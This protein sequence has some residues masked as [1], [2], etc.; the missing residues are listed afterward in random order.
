MGFELT[1]GYVITHLVIESPGG[2]GGNTGLP[3]STHVSWTYPFHFRESP[4]PP[5][6]SG[7]AGSYPL[8][9]P[10]VSL[11][12]IILPNEQD[13]LTSLRRL[14]VLDTPKEERFDRITRLAARVLDFPFAA[15]TLIDSDRQWHKSTVGISLLQ[16]PRTQSFC[17]HAVAANHGYVVFDASTDARFR[18]NPIVVNAPQIRFYASEVI[19]SA[20]GFALGTLCI[21]DSQP[22][23]FSD[24]DR[25]I[26]RDL[27]A[28]VERE[29]NDAG[30]PKLHEEKRLIDAAVDS[31]NEGILIYET[32]GRDGHRV[33]YANPAFLRMTGYR[34]LEIVGRSPSFL[35][36]PLTDPKVVVE[37]NDSV[38][39]GRSFS[40][41]IV[42]YRKDGT[43][44]T[45]EW[46]V[47]P[48]RND[49][50]TVTHVI[51]VWR[52]ISERKQAE[53]V[54]VATNAQLAHA[55]Q[56]ADNASQ[57][58]SHFLASMSHELRTPLNGIMGMAELLGNSP[59]TNDQRDCVSTIRQSS[60]NLLTIISDVLDFSKIEFGKLE[61]DPQPFSPALL[62][63]DVISLLGGRAQKAGIELSSFV[64]PELPTSLVGD[65]NRLRQV[66]LNLVGNAIKFTDR[67]E[68]RLELLCGPTSQ[69]GKPCMAVSVC[70]TGIG[71][72]AERMGR[73]FQLFSQVDPSTTRV[74]GGT[75]LGLAIAQRLVQL[76][77]GEIAV[78]SDVGRGSAFSFAVALPP[79]EG[80]RA[81]SPNL[82]STRVALVDSNILA[83]RN[84][85]RQLG[86]WGAH[87]GEFSALGTTGTAWDAMMVAVRSRE[88]AVELIGTLRSLYAGPIIALTP[89]YAY[90]DSQALA[91]AGATATLSLPF[92]QAALAAA[93]GA[94]TGKPIASVFTPSPLAPK[95][96][97]LPALRVLVAEDNSTNRKVAL[98]M[99]AQLG[100]SAEV[101]SSGTEAVDLAGSRDYDVILMD[102]HMPDLDGLEAS[103]RIRQALATARR[104]PYIIAMTA[105]ALLGDREK[106]LSAGMDNYITKPV[107]L[108]L[109]R[110]ALAGSPIG[111]DR[112]A[113][114]ERT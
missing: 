73:L 81:T 69:G 85:A 101:A 102:V 110:A 27:A 79:A 67:G 64:D 10:T 49:H 96:A 61:F 66:L 53:R 80:A 28:L 42:N 83:R 31:I 50:G 22:R 4:P 9:R 11:A 95:E 30:D 36:G 75:G 17:A 2:Q 19:R 93:V 54:L 29:I 59:L 45:S 56:Q 24:S 41:E 15:V 77:G 65:A 112:V 78:Q 63:D 97:E 113:R 5:G 111:L 107:K 60:E 55:K 108:A 100:L 44:F 105:D 57:A 106:C 21:M 68:V 52:D 38:Q 23:S 13:R 71:I 1:P 89:A 46:T 6:I 18:G 104:Q 47:S 70:D 91:E 14:S 39:A 94:A 62:A 16:I 26:L 7:D 35:L 37:A 109:L 82:S 86:A 74:Y 87:C 76:M 8:A 43:A 98:G 33:F 48:I 34:L 114:S 3:P 90:L 20:E 84:L 72:P 12:P 51:S 92:R 32:G 99:L 25:E 103:R 88:E 58:K 40:G